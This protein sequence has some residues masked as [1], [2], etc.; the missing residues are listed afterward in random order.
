M[1]AAET[2]VEHEIAALTELRHR[3][4]GL[5]ERADPLLRPHYDVIVDRISALIDILSEG[6]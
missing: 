5:A 2:N 1:K 3:A 4:Q 6:P